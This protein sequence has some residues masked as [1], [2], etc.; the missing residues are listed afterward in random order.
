MREKMQYMCRRECKEIK[1]CIIRTLRFFARSYITLFYH[2]KPQ[3][4]KVLFLS[5]LAPL[6]DFYN[7]TYIEVRVSQLTGTLQ[8]I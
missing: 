5:V 7:V 3:S 2:A 6:R 1:N 8:E 4:R